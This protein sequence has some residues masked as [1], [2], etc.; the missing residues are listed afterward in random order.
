MKQKIGI[1]SVVRVVIRWMILLFRRIKPLI[2][3]L[4]QKAKYCNSYLMSKVKLKMKT[5]FQTNN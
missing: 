4:V 5:Y 3:K 2:K 1:K